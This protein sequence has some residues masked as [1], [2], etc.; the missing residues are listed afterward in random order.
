LPDRRR[1]KQRGCQSQWRWK[2]AVAC[3]AGLALLLCFAASCSQDPRTRFDRANQAFVHGE[4]VRA[5]IEADAAAK[6]YSERSPEWAWRF[7]LLGARTRGC[8]CKR[9]I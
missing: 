6:Y 2:R 3:E 5:Q 8:L 4:L 7:R 9:R 1:I